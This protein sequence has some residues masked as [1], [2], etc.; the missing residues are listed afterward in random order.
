MTP[1]IVTLIVSNLPNFAGFA[2]LALVQW[3]VF[4]RMADQYDK[5]LLAFL[6]LMRDCGAAPARVQ[7]VSQN[8]RRKR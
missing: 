3:L 8:L 2:V 7:A 6:E 4:R 1:D 5:L